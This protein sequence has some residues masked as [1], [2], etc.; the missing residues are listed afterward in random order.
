MIYGE[1]LRLPGEFLGSTSTMNLDNSDDFV[2]D[3]RQ[4]FQALRPV[5][6]TRHGERKIFVFKDLATASHVFVRHDAVRRPLQHPYDGPFEVVS[7]AEKHY[8]LR[9]HGTNVPVSI[10]RLKPAY[11][12]VNE[13]S[14]EDAVNPNEDDEDKGIL[15]FLPGENSPPAQQPIPPAPAEP[16]AATQAPAV[17]RPYTT[18]SG[19]QVRFPERFQAGM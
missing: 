11:I 3:L 12:A 8:T 13:S 4:H 7:R 1:P 15:F 19:R 9:I 14:P 10:D 6:G 18:R 5:S 2:R 17:R 16:E